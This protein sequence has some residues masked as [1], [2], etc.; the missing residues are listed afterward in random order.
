[1]DRDESLEQFITVLMSVRAIL[2][3]LLLL[4][5]VGL[6][7]V[8][9]LYGSGS[10]L[11][12]LFGAVYLTIIL[13]MVQVYRIRKV[14]GVSNKRFLGL[15]FESLLC[16]P[17][18]LNI[19]RKLSLYHPLLVDPVGFASNSFD[20]VTFCQLADAVLLRVDEQLEL[21]EID[22]LSYRSLQAY[23]ERIKGMV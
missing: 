21:E 19:M 15:A 10:Q 12:W 14:L 18:A 6:P 7:L 17:F 9:F 22:S 4:F 13:I 23:Q 20:R 16:A 2:V 3:V 11:L 8:L 1:V 5:L